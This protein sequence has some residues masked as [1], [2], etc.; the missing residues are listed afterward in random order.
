VGADLS[1]IRSVKTV[2][3]IVVIVP[4]R[5]PLVAIA[6]GQS[7]RDPL[8]LAGKSSSTFQRWDLLQ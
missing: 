2:L 6:V 7:E 3:Y 1:S 4:S 8:A 5:R